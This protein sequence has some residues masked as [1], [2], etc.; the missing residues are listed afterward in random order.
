MVVAILCFF[1]LTGCGTKKIDVMETVTLTYSGVN[2]YGTANI[3]NAYDW[4]ADALKQA[5]IETVDDLASFGGALTIEFAVSYE[6]YPKENLSNGDEVT[7]KASIDNEAVEQFKIKFIGQEKKFTVQGLKEVQYVDLFENIDVDYQGIAPNVS[8][9]VSDAN[10]DCYVQTRYVLDKNNNLDIGDTV[11]V[12]AEYDKDKLLE[13]GYMAESDTKEFVVSG[14]AKYVTELAEIPEES[15][16]QLKKQT[17]DIIEADVAKRTKSNTMWASDNVCSLSNKTF[18]GNYF[19]KA[20]DIGSAYRKNYY[21]YVYQ[22]D[23]T[24]KYDFS[25]YYTVGYYD[26]AINE[27]N[28]CIYD[29]DKCINPNPSISVSK[30]TF[31]SGYEDLDKLYNDCITQN[32][33]DYT[34]E[35]SVEE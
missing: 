6:V 14:V 21:Y 10:T 28:M 25:C 5:G 11:T 18:L 35:S 22:L 32:L 8:A 1:A 4:E 19:L 31:Y 15:I 7:V 9:T 24:G 26:L 3:E 29:F 20:K 17:E 16:D 2:G 27:E 12:S 13:A 33:V 30:V 23:F 34:C